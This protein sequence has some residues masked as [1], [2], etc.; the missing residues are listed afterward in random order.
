VDAWLPAAYA[1]SLAAVG[2]VVL[3][4]GQG[5][6]PHNAVDVGPGGL[7]QVDRLLDEALGLRRTRAVVESGSAWVDRLG[8]LADPRSVVEVGPGAGVAVPRGK[9]G[10]QATVRAVEA[11]LNEPLLRDCIVLAAGN[12]RLRAESSARIAELARLRSRLVGVEAEERRRL[13]DRLRAGPLTELG[14]LSADLRSSGVPVE[15]SAGVERT[16]VALEEIALGLDPMTSAASAVEAL[17]R[18]VG[19][20]AVPATLR[21]D[22][23]EVPEALGRTIWFVCAESLANVAKHAPGSRVQVDL[24]TIGGETVLQ[25]SDDGPGGADPDGR[26]LRGVR[27]RVFA[28]DGALEVDSGPTG[29]CL[30][31]RFSVAEHS[32]QHVVRTSESTDAPVRRAFVASG[33]RQPTEE[34]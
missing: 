27:D 33:G 2:V 26:G 12:L 32:G 8:E 22:G 4:T 31:A 28:A 13:L 5:L 11:S 24:R 20:S 29:T 9:G 21:S 23:T 17:E 3:A 34:P 30:R 14:R 19:R 6:R 16:R 10:R 1:S 15:M 18:L 7:A 25:V